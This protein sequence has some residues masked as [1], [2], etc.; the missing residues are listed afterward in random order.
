MDTTVNVTVQIDE[1]FR[2]MLHEDLV[3]NIDE[4]KCEYNMPN[5]AMDFL[6]RR[7]R[8]GM[9]ARFEIP[10]HKLLDAEVPQSVNAFRDDA[11]QFARLVLF[12][13]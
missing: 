6:I 5:D 11:E 13:A 1:T 10:R 3:E 4:V 8:D 12:L 2:T 7:K 9:V